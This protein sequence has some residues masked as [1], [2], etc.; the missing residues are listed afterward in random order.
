MGFQRY[1]GPFRPLP[2]SPPMDCVRLCM[3]LLA[4]LAVPP[5]DIDDGAGLMREALVAAY[6]APV[7]GTEADCVAAVARSLVSRRSWWS[8]AVLPSRDPANAF[9]CPDGTILIT[10]GLVEE[11]ASED[12]IAFVIAHEAAHVLLGHASRAAREAL[13]AAAC[14]A[15]VGECPSSG[16]LGPTVCEESQADA[17]ALELVERAGRDPLAGVR[18]LT[19]LVTMGR[20][21]ASW[22]HPAEW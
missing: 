4:T 2:E 11:C 13:A 22:A 19:R 21:H 10:R 17:L 7:E 18:L 12:E 3:A 1:A 6:G 8:T 5:S 9:A 15:L 14:W 20:G 16:W